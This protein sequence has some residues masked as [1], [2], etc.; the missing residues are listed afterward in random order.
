M[1]RVAI[2]W[3]ISGKIT[4]LM[5]HAAFTEVLNPRCNSLPAKFYA[6]QKGNN[7]PEMAHMGLS[8]SIG[9]NK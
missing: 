2:I 3:A 4:S 9:N 5:A 8:S 1:S 6:T 7:M